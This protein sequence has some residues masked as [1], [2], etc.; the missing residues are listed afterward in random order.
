MGHR[1][2]RIAAFAILLGGAAATAETPPLLQDRE[3]WAL[4]ED[5]V[6]IRF[7]SGDPGTLLSSVR[8][9]HWPPLAGET[10]LMTIATRPATGG[11]YGITRNLQ[12]AR[13]DP[14]T[15]TISVVGPKIHETIPGFGS[16]YMWLGFDARRDVARVIDGYGHQVR[17]DPETGAVIDGAPGTAGV[18]SDADWHWAEGDRNDDGYTGAV[19][20]A[21]AYANGSA[22]STAY[23]IVDTIRG[24]M[25]VR[26]GEGGGAAAADGGVITTIGVLGGFPG[27]GLVPY[28]FVVSDGAAL[29][30]LM[31]PYHAG[32]YVVG[33]D[34]EG[35]VYGPKPTWPQGAN[36]PEPETMIGPPGKGNYNALAEVPAGAPQPP[37]PDPEPDPDPAPGP[38]PAPAPEPAETVR[39]LKGTIQFSRLR[40]PADAVQ[41]EGVVGLDGAASPG[42]DVRVRLGSIDHTFQLDARLRAAEGGDRI[43][44]LPYR[45][46]GQRFRIQF[47]REDLAEE[48]L[49]AERGARFTIPLRLTVDGEETIGPVH[50]VL[51]AVTT[52]RAVGVVERG[53]ERR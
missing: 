15:G 51:R 49:T 44:F 21:F 25:L 9:F 37:A 1:I 24:Q 36:S 53:G 14:V 33:V 38:G 45:G 18:Q 31:H 5:G 43:R 19:P 22:T 13:V 40:H 35:A 7:R 11:L 10:P 42:D 17:L 41:L 28:G 48:L 12:L 26:L 3:V 20:S 46:N 50:L 23:G 29:M 47:D 34:L 30:E 6:L 8:L 4:E 27:G 39:V 52:A 2:G 32:A 16:Q